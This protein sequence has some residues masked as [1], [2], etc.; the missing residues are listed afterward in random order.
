MH[1]PGLKVVMPSTPYDA[2]GLLKTAIRD[3]NPV[4]FLEHKRLYGAKSPGGQSTTGAADLSVAFKPAPAAEY[5]VPF[6]QADVKRTGR[7]AT[8][9]AT[10]LM[11]HRSLKAAETL[12]AEGI[13]VEVID[14]RTLVPLDKESI[15]RSVAKTSRLIVV[16]EDERTCGVA[17]EI[18][19]IVAQE[20]LMYL[21][22]PVQRVSVPDTPIPFAPIMEDAVIPNEER[23]VHA[24]KTALG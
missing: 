4:I 12:A 16:S 8:I 18:C 17:A 14:P 3:D 11:V 7:D 15:L 23:I 2:K 21:D 20:G 22:A 24:V 10:G 19:A 9:V 5:T 6:G 1:T 13:E